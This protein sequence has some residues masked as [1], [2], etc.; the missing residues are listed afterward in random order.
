MTPSSSWWTFEGL[1][2]KHRLASTVVLSTEQRTTSTSAHG[3]TSAL[4]MGPSA[5]YISN[6]TISIFIKVFVQLNMISMFTIVCTSSSHVHML[7]K[8]LLHYNIFGLD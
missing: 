3:A 4:S 2:C 7:V 8:N 5:G 1:H 6:L